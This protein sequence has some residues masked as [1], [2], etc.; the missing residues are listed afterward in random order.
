MAEVLLLMQTRAADLAMVTMAVEEAITMAEVMTTTTR[1]AVAEEV[2]VEEP[3]EAEVQEAE[4]AEQHL[5]QE[6]KLLRLETLVLL[7]Q[8]E[9]P[10]TVVA[11]AEVLGRQEMADLFPR[12]TTT[13]KITS[14]A[15][16]ALNVA[17]SNQQLNELYSRKVQI[18]AESFGLVPS[19]EMKDVASLSGQTAS[20]ME[21]LVVVVPE[22][23]V[24]EVVTI[25]LS[26][27]RELQ[28]TS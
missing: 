4:G 22:E 21:V 9:V 26:R 12:R 24:M 25:V 20:R 5:V 13:T 27:R 16:K 10:L 2:E 3:G 14:M 18:L 11:E 8:E 1:M 7:L 17:V 23:V 19:H 28:R 6:I 15:A